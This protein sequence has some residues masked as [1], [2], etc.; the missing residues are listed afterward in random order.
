MGAQKIKNCFSA[1]LMQNVAKPVLMPIRFLQFVIDSVSAQFHWPTN[2]AMGN[3]F[4]YLYEQYIDN[5]KT[6]LRTHC[7][8]RLRLFFKMRVYEHN[9]FVMFHQNNPNSFMLGEDDV[10]N[11]INYTIK[12]RDTTRNANERIQLQVLLDA[13][14]ECGAPNDCDIRNY[15]DNNWFKSLYMWIQI[16]RDIQ[17]FQHSYA[18]VR[19]SWNLFRKHPLYVQ[20]PQAPEPPKIHNF[21]A[22]PICSNQRRHIRIDTQ[23]L[24]N[25]VC[26]IKIVPQKIGESKKQQPINIIRNEFFLNKSGSWFIYFNKDLIVKM[27]KNKKMFAHQIVSDGVSVSVIYKRPDQPE[28]EIPKEEVRRRF[29][30]GNFWYLL[31]ID[32]GMRTYNATVRRCLRTGEEVI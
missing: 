28:P 31:G 2:T 9:D 14:I 24:Y 19:A 3:A 13:L 8:R 4:N 18:N 10:K 23:V 25:L 6:N 1:V 32:P 30:L 11:A 12:R 29:E 5:V 17:Q 7:E 26:R 15:V 16:Q 22:I 21:A 27:V 20:R